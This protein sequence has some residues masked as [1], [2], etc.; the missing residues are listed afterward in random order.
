MFRRFESDKTSRICYLQIS[1]YV[2]IDN[3][4]LN[5]LTWPSIM[6][7]FMSSSQ[8]GQ[9]QYKGQYKNI[10]PNYDN[11]MITVRCTYSGI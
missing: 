5:T 2:M 6:T 11:I 3:W 4:L 8:L 7:F 10:S 1:K 9:I